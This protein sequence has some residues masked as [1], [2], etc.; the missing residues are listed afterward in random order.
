[1]ATDGVREGRAWTYARMVVDA[2]AYAGVVTIATVVL[3][4]TIG[5]VT[6]GGAVLGK[7]L[8]FIAGWLFV[9]IATVRL[10]PKSPRQVALEGESGGARGTTAPGG[11]RIESFADT[12]PPLRWM[13]RPARQ[14]SPPTK[15]FIAGLLVLLSSYLLETVFAV[16]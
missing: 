4:L 8:L 1:M 7:I 9:G 5:I 2:L 14:L 10:W 3:A 13:R 6:G 12:L 15:L 11:T 16:R